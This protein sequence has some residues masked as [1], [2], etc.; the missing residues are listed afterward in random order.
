MLLRTCENRLCGK[1]FKPQ[2]STLSQPKEKQQRFCNK[3][4]R[5]QAYQRG[6][7]SIVPRCSVEISWPL[8]SQEQK[9]EMEPYLIKSQG[10][11]YV[12]R[13]GEYDVDVSIADRTFTLLRRMLVRL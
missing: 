1:Q 6:K 9:L 10:Y 5:E 11:G 2:E 8:L 4:C 7:H 3:D 12:L 13:V